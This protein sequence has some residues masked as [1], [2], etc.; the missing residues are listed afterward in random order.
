MWRE[1]TRL[2]PKLLAALDRNERYV[3]RSNEPYDFRINNWFTLERHG[4]AIGLPC[5]YI[6]I[7]NDLIEAGNSLEGYLAEAITDSVRFIGA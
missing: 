5:A 6:E 3:V 1:D 7:R 2:A 4:L